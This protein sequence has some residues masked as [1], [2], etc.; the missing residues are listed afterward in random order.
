MIPITLIAC[1]D[2]KGGIGKDGK[3]PWN[4]PEDLARFKRLTMGYPVIMGRKTFESI[5]R[6][7]PGRVNIVLTHDLGW[8]QEFVET[9]NSL[10]EALAIAE[11]TIAGRAF[12]IGGAEIYKQA[13]PLAS[14]IELTVIDRDFD[15][16]TFF[17]DEDERG[18]E[19]ID[20]QY[21]RGRSTTGLVYCFA[22]YRKRR[23]S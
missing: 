13:L 21:K 10:K 5:G 19:W 12:V 14:I 23:Q 18:A 1:T 4:L 3:M 20:A 16:D 8:T 9:A 2:N 7:L 17:P 22:T 11:A 6:P 15:C